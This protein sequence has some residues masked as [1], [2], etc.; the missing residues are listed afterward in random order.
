MLAASAD[1]RLQEFFS[2]LFLLLDT[3]GTY[4]GTLNE[5]ILW[6]VFSYRPTTCEAKSIKPAR[7]R[8]DKA[9]P[10]RLPTRLFISGVY[11]PMYLAVNL[12]AGC[13]SVPG[14]SPGIPILMTEKLSERWAG[15]RTAGWRRVCS[16]VLPA[17]AICTL[18]YSRYL[19]PDATPCRPFAQSQESLM[20]YPPWLL[21]NQGQVFHSC[22]SGP[23]TPAS[24]PAI[25]LV[26]SEP[27]RGVRPERSG[28]FHVAFIGSEG[29][30]A[31]IGGKIPFRTRTT[32]MPCILYHQPRATYRASEHTRCSTERYQV[33]SNLTSN[34]AH[35]SVV[36]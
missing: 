34:T 33:P 28:L 31:F 18:W 25:G 24:H 16:A 1:V 14:P 5:V 3:K 21:C 13:R 7:A 19:A 20:P 2:L 4:L 8:G 6:R 30:A 35:R 23:S 11:R 9:K 29:L 10:T 12:W 15:G 32:S 26:L 22:T 27:A 36:T 17:T